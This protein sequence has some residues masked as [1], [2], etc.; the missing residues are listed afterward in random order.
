MAEDA[1]AGISGAGLQQYHNEEI[2]ACAEAR[3]KAGPS[4]HGRA[5]PTTAAAAAAGGSWGD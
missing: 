4:A 3:R 5:H 1:G 2:S